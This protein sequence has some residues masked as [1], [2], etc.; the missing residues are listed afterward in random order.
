MKVFEIL[1]DDV[2]KVTEQQVIDRMVAFDWKYEFSDNVSRMAWGQRELELIENQVYQ[3]WKQNPAR[4]VELWN[5][6]SPG[7]P[8]DKSVE[9]SFIF[10]L[11]AQEK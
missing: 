1:R 8:E 4:A 2:Q 10:R 5:T 6:H 11:Q 3:L 7:A 9:P